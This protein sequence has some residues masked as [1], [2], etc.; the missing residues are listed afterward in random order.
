[1]ILWISRDFKQILWILRNNW[2]N[3]I[4]HSLSQNLNKD[5]YLFYLIFYGREREREERV[6]EKGGE[7]GRDS[8]ILKEK[9]ILRNLMF[10]WKTF[11]C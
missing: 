10:S 8:K 4:T 1:M 2:K 9:T 7:R 6:R 5:S 3:I 11:S